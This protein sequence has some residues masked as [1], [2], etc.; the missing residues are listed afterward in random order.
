MSA[1]K[2]TFSAKAERCWRPLPDWVKQLAIEADRTSASMAARRLG[3]S[4]GVVS[5][6]IGNAYKGNI[7]AVAGK[8]KGALMGHEVLCPV[9]GEV[10]RDRCLSEQKRGFIGTSALR[11]R[12]Y[13]ACRNGCEHSLINKKQGGEDVPA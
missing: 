6:V 8:V 10:R 11:T 13:N 9:L 5:A 7:E 1:A 4:V 3:Y 12:L 2:E